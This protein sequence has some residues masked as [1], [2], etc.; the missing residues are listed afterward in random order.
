VLHQQKQGSG[1]PQLDSALAAAPTGVLA[2][3]STPVPLAPDSGLQCEWTDVRY[4]IGS[5]EIRG[6]DEPARCAQ[7]E[8]RARFWWLADPLWS[9]P[10]NA[11]WSEHVARMISMR[12]HYDAQRG[13]RDR[14]PTL[15][16]P[17]PFWPQALHEQ[18]T[19]FGFYN[20][21]RTRFEMRGGEKI[22]RAE[23]YV[24]GGYSFAPD[25]TRLLEPMEST[26]DDWD[27]TW[28]GGHERMVT[29]ETWHNL[30]HYQAVTL[31]RGEELLVLAAARLP[32]LVSAFDD[33]WAA[34]AM[35]RL[36]DLDIEVEPARVERTGVVRAGLQLE[37]ADWLASLEMLGPEWRARAR[38]G[39]PA[40]V[41]DA[42][43]FGVSDPTLVAVG[44]EGDERGLLDAVVPS[45]AIRAGPVG[46]YFEIYGSEESESLDV[47]LAIERR[48]RSLVRR[49]VGKLGFGSGV[50]FPEVRW[51]EVTGAAGGFVARHFVL[52]LSGLDQGEYELRIQVV[53]SDGSSASSSRDMRVIQR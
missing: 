42:V 33:V 28:N 49:L 18:W 4:L 17:L 16:E 21:W 41:L 6:D 53:R 34:L 12:L 20:S 30:E 44:F 45:T 38:H 13:A 50:T 48:S 8:F 3:G 37:D 2:F 24:N 25:P 7:E 22:E 23:L 32:V 26:T 27:V 52:D 40:P 43:G 36:K 11:R 9:E 14:P 46:M 19:R 1:G 10:G 39:S 47:R 5:D 29:V 35:G 15:S 31:R 51:R